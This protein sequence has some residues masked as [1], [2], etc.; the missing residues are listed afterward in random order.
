MTDVAVE[1]E[2]RAVWRRAAFYLP[3]YDPRRPRV[4]HALITEELATAGPLRGFTAEASGLS[5]DDG[6]M[7]AFRIEARGAGADAWATTTEVAILR[8]DDLARPAF[9]AP[10]GERL[11]KLLGT[12]GDLVR[13]GVVSRLARIDKQFAAF[14]LYPYVATLVLGLL[15]LAAALGAAAALWSLSP[16]AAIPGAL[17]AAALGTWLALRLER[18]LFLRYLLEDWLFSFAHERGETDALAER[19]DVFAQAIVAA[20]RRPEIDEILV[21]GH[22]SGAFLAPE[23]LAAALERDPDLGRRGPVVSILTIGTVAPLM[24]VDETCGRY[25]AAVARLADEAG[26]VWHEVQSRHDAMNVCPADPVALSGL[27]A[28]PTRWPKL[29]RLSMP[30]LVAPGR[31]GLFRERLFFFRTHF[32]FLRANERIHW[33]DFYGMLAGPRTLAARHADVPDMRSDG[34][35]TPARG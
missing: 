33:Y 3:G 21:V 1:A 13:R 29:M 8:W 12:G 24:L 19:L 4:Y 34:T 17:A 25:R 9:H 7:P 14:V 15:V 23:T 10:L 18:P 11:A 35:L 2:E 28:A 20:A 26:I 22:S 31:L 6:P 30:Q 27:V 32:R 16:L 5:G